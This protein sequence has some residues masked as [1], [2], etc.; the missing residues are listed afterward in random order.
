MQHPIPQNIM[1][2]EFKL[3]GDLTLKQFAYLAIGFGL[4]YMIFASPLSIY[5]KYPLILL[6][7]VLGLLFAFF[8]LDD[9]GLDIWLLN[10]IR[11]IY[12]PQR[13][14]WTKQGYLPPALTLELKA[15]RTEGSKAGGQEP[16]EDLRLQRYLKSHQQQL[17]NVA[18]EHEN[19]L[20]KRISALL[21][22]E[23]KLARQLAPSIPLNEENAKTTTEILAEGRTEEVTPQNFASHLNYNPENSPVPVKIIGDQMVFRSP[24]KN[25]VVNRPLSTTI[26][27]PPNKYLKPQATFSGVPK[28]IMILP[29]QNNLREI[30]EKPEETKARNEKLLTEVKQIINALKDYGH[31]VPQPILVPKASAQAPTT[32]P[33]PTPLPIRPKTVV[34]IDKKTGEKMTLRVPKP[35]APETSA[36]EMRT[37][38]LEMLTQQNTAILDKIEQ[39]KS[40]LE[41]IQQGG[42]GDQTNLTTPTPQETVVKEVIRPIP[43]AQAPLPPQALQDRNLKPTTPNS[44]EQP[45]LTVQPNIING[46][47]FGR[48]QELVANAIVLIMDNSNIPKW[49]S[50]T[51]SAGQFVMSTP[52]GNGRYR[53]EVQKPNLTFDTIEL[54]AN[55]NVLKP[56]FIK[57]R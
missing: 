41:K 40:T 37:Q 10:Y 7:G 44:K 21:T 28:K 57:A 35:P 15:I 20:L 9:R 38:K 53:I 1:D 23:M 32:I 24:I 39:A 52:V 42:G 55:G 12:R 2:V 16:P 14:I 45:P 18:E 48:N 3:V 43:V 46:I 11:A 8:P 19:N 56:T 6:F 27:S 36:E 50:R 31:A 13:R 29:A 4:S 34:T 49:A 22:D 54:E 51:N 5:I 33:N 30:P 17:H 26:V 47:V 25:V